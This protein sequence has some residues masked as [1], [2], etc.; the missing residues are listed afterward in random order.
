M[1]M[2]SVKKSLAFL[3]L[4]AIIV[5]MA[6]CSGTSEVVETSPGDT[7]V[8]TASAKQTT[9]KAQTTTAKAETTTADA[10]P[11]AEK[12]VIN[13]L[14]GTYSS[15]LYEEGRWDELE[16]EEKFNVDLKMW[17]ILIDSSNMEQVQ[18]MLAAGDVPDWGFYYTSG[19]YL[20]ENGLGRTIP[21]DMIR[22]YLPSYYKMLVDEPLGFK[23]NLV[24]GTEDEYYGISMNTSSAYVDGFVPMWRLDWL[25]TLGY[26]LEN[27]EPMISVIKPE[28]WNERVYY[29]TTLFT[30]DDVREIL[31]GF[32][33]DDPDGNGVDDTFG[34]GFA[35]SWYD[36]YLSYVMFG[37][38]KDMNH[39]YKDPITGDYVPYIAYAPYRDSLVFLTE[40]IDK[41]YMRFV[42]GEMDYWLELRGIWNTAKTGFMNTLGAPRVL[43]LGYGDGDQ[44]PPA[45]ILDNTD[46]DA[47]FVITPCLGS[48]KYLPYTPF[49]WDERCYTVGNISDE[50]MIRLFQ[51]LE[52]AYFGE[53]WLRYKWG[54]EG[55]HY[56]WYS[57][58]FK[59]PV[60]FTEADK[61]PAKYAGKGTKTFGQFGNN[62]FITDIKVVNNFDAHCVQF[63]DYWEKHGGYYNEKLWLR[64]EK[65][66]NAFT[67]P[68]DRYEE[69]KELREETIDQISTVHNEFSSR[70]WSGQIANINTEWEQYIDRLYAAGLEEWVEIWNG[71]DIKTFKEYRDA[72]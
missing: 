42:P 44:W 31:R 6:A 37:F 14:V 63:I 50:K 48:G 51:L 10:N 45:N 20:Y 7:V 38:T 15:H 70:V 67:M 59:S 71:S 55:V 1:K 66:Y 13:W 53:D 35:N 19:K 72:N 58:P 27:L 18:M 41:G 12:M 8:T 32:T 29:S 69:F 2:N 39:F 46:P 52:Y 43:G 54:I 49:N 56:K 22:Q 60:I 23:F 36:C 30:E 26:T 4:L 25:E 21:L 61:I 47:T 64:P 11:F 65:F 34:S 3:L 17:N 16:L 9:T 40:M 28:V 33:E 5:S 62:N 68:A 24:E 57:E